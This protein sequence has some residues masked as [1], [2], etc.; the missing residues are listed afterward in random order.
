MTRL[1]E[2][3]GPADAM[4]KAASEGI[5][6][7]AK[8]L[9]DTLDKW[10][11]SQSAIPQIKR[12]QVSHLLLTANTT[13]TAQ[14]GDTA[15]RHMIEISLLTEILSIDKSDQKVQNAVRSTL[16]LCSQMSQEPISLLW[17]LLTAGAACIGDENRAWVRQLI[18]VFRPFYCQDLEV[19]VC[20]ISCAHNWS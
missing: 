8:A 15:Y 14:N 20:P 10:S 18:D 13:L 9:L 5:V 17:P 19:A 11:L 3:G 16:E 7:S 4:S 6:E 1:R 12:I 2:K